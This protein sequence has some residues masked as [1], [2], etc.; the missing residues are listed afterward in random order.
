MGSG[1]ANTVLVL[2]KFCLFPKFFQE[3]DYGACPFDSVTTFGC[4]ENK[5]KIQISTYELLLINVI[6]HNLKKSCLKI[7]S[8]I[9][10]YLFV[11]MYKEQ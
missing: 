9:G 3:Y 8:K 10:K 6:I 7:K 11:T 1:S 2:A 4:K 5:D